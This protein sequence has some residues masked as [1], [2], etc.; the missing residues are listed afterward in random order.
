MKDDNIK[1][2]LEEQGSVQWWMG[3]IGKLA[4]AIIA[5]AVLDYQKGTPE[6]RVDA[7]KFL[8]E[9]DC[10]FWKNFVTLAPGWNEDIVPPEMQT[11]LTQEEKEE[12]VTLYRQG[13]IAVKGLAIKFKCPYGT[14]SSFIKSVVPAAE[15]K[16]IEDTRKHRQH[17]GVIRDRLSGVST[18]NA[19]L[20]NHVA[21]WKVLDWFREFMIQKG[22]TG[23]DYMQ[24]L[25]ELSKRDRGNVAELA[26]R[27]IEE[28]EKS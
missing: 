8:V 15:M 10:G 4:A 3:P 26:D 28:L 11:G 18:H 24:F 23:K 13:M 21:Q 17:V 7:Y 5:R 16:Q 20:F 25:Q 27:L 19:A 2:L 22:I 9:E 1:P 6:Q 12:A 14:M